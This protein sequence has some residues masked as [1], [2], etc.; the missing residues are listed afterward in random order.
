MTAVLPRGPRLFARSRRILATIVVG[1]AVAVAS[2][3]VG[4]ETFRL[5]E[6]SSINLQVGGYLTLIP[7]V[8]IA[9][10]SASPIAAQEH[11]ANRKMWAW[12]GLSVCSGSIACAVLLVACSALNTEVAPPLVELRNLAGFEGLALM[13]AAVFG[14][15]LSWT[16][17]LVWSILP[18]V[19][20]PD[21]ESDR[22]GVLTFF[23]QPQASMTA[24]LFAALVFVIGIA[25]AIRGIK[26]RGIVGSL[27]R[28]L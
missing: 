10:A 26:S 3:L 20:L 28:A 22:V 24:S 19:V 7:G 14:S 13:A 27:S 1:A 11:L 2:A 9:S 18:A 25:G 4:N 12:R 8:V 17:P 16:V 15:H 6:M 5:V 23:L 21:L